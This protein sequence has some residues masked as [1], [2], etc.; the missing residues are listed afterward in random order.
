MTLEISIEDAFVR[1]V[2]R[3]G[4]K[5]RKLVLAS[6][7]GWPDRSIPLPGGRVCWVEFKRPGRQGG[8]SP[9]QRVIRRE[10]EGLGHAVL[11]TDSLEEAV[12]FFEE[13]LERARCL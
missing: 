5:A 1:H 2:E 9:Q 8:E 10:L 6:E 4:Y 7:R 13:Q 12:A 11:L 3:R